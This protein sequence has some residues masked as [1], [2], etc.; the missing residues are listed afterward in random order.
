MRAVLDDRA[1]LQRM[2][3]FEAALARAEAA[4]GDRAAEP[5]RHAS[6]R[7]A[8]P[9]ST[10]S[11]RWREAA[12]PA[13]NL[14]IPLVN[15]LTAEVGKRSKKAA[16]YV[17]WGATSQ[18]VI[19]TALVLELRAVIDA[20]LADLDRATKAFITLAGR[21][22]RNMTVART[23]LQQALPMP[24]GLKL[25]GY[26]AALA[27]SRDR[28]RA[29]AQGSAGAA[30]R[31]RRR[32]ARGAR[33][34]RPRRFRAA[35]RAAR[36]HRARRALAQ[37]PR[38]PC[39]SRR[40]ARDPRRHLRQ[41]RARRGAAD[42]DRGR[43]S[44]RASTPGR[45]GS[46]T[47][48]HKRNPIGAAAALSAAMIAPNLAATILTAQIQEHERA[49]GGWQAEWMTF[50]AL[51]LVMSGTLRAVVE[52][53]EGLDVDVERMK[54]NLEASGGLVLAEAVSFALAE[55]A[56]PG[57]GARAG[58]GAQPRRRQRKSARSR[59]SW[60]RTTRSRRRS[61]PPSSKSCS[62]RNH[63]QGSA[64]TFIDR[65]VASSQG[66]AVR[67]SSSVEPSDRAENADRAA[68]PSLGDHGRDL[69]HQGD[70]RRRE[71]T[72][73]APAEPEL[74]GASKRPL[75]A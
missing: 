64:Q 1:R 26:A 73:P 2:L 17:H 36:S 11:R 53:A 38:P 69:G 33:R 71:T 41:D 9:S 3:D 35:R 58:R 13:G 67:R 22:R 65:L 48:P 42:A 29:A 49:V 74:R 24:F 62:C 31:R 50:P 20:L 10:I 55:Q 18:D 4:V 43:R 59:T 27:R 46:S 28:L 72:V 40:R 51:A 52:I 60:R 7:P 44:L 16:G 19:D 23:L 32:H 56:R 34:E 12:I 70:C 57:R 14:A 75:A 5:R 37:P 68:G 45:G 8:R 63:Y 6:P 54:A 25:A 47:L 66:R 15:A 39:R 61:A 21:H 30:I